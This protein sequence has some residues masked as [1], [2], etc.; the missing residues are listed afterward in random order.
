MW[1]LGT[2]LVSSERAVYTFSSSFNSLAPRMG[3]FNTMIVVCALNIEILV[4]LYSLF[5]YSI[6][7]FLFFFFFYQTIKLSDH[8]VL[9]VP[10]DMCSRGHLKMVSLSLLLLA[11]CISFPTSILYSFTLAMSW[12]LV[13]FHTLFYLSSSWGPEVFCL[14]VLPLHAS[15]S[16]TAVFISLC[17][18]TM[19]SSS[20]SRFS[21]RSV[22]LSCTFPLLLLYYFVLFSAFHPVGTSIEDNQRETL[23]ST[24]LSL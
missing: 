10:F 6:C 21:V 9:P 3:T 19:L 7:I 5:L 8:F 15:P 13:Y 11:L 22:F 14:F 2:K 17:V 4:F 23:L 16:V 20:L 12:P 1:V 24:H 18:S